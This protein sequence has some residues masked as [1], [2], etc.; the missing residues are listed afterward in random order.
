MSNQFERAQYLHSNADQLAAEALYE[1]Y[2][3]LSAEQQVQALRLSQGTLEQQPKPYRN[4]K[5]TDN[6]IKLTDIDVSVGQA[7]LHDKRDFIKTAVATIFQNKT[8]EDRQIIAD[9]L[10]H[11]STR[12]KTPSAA[13]PYYKYAYDCAM[14]IINQGS[15]Q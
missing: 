12:D 13:R 5:V 11:K 7:M 8:Q 3:Q 6:A 15:N 2:Q 9:V 4:V 1:A 10:L 14:N